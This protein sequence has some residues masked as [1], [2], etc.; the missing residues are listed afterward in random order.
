M[1]KLHLLHPDGSETAL[2][3]Q[4]GA[5]LLTVLHEHLGGHPSAPCGGNS[6]CLKC[7]VRITDGA[8]GFSPSLADRKAFS[9][10]QLESGW[11]LACRIIL[12]AESELWLEHPG[13]REGEVCETSLVGRAPRLDH[14]LRR[15]TLSLPPP[16]INDQRPDDQRLLG[17]LQQDESAATGCPLPVLRKLP[18]LLRGHSFRLDAVL[19]K[20]KI[21]DVRP[22]ASGRLLGAAVDLGT[23]TVALALYDLADGRLLHIASAGNRQAEFG[24]DVI[25]RITASGK[26]DGI[27]RLQRAAQE[28][29][30]TLLREACAACG[31][32]PSGLASL[33]VAG[34]TV[35]QHLLAGVSPSGIGASPFTPAFTAGLTLTLA[36]I[37][38]NPDSAEASH[39][40][41]ETAP[42]YLLPCIGPYVGGDITAGILSQYLT[43]RDGNHLLIDAG[44]NG[45]IVLRA[46][47]KLYACSTA[48]GPA[49]E[50]ARISCGM[51]ACDGAIHEIALNH[52]LPATK[53]ASADVWPQET[54][55][56]V[57]TLHGSDA[58]GVCGSGLLD[59]VARLLDTGL[60]DET[61][62]L[63]DADELTE[64]FPPKLRARLRDDG[65]L[66][67]DDVVLTRKD[68]REFQ[69]AC[70]AIQA[71]ARVLLKE[72]GI[73]AGELDGVLLAGGFGSH[74]SVGSALRTGLIPSGVSAEKVRAAGNAS[75]AGARLCL[76]EEAARQEAE[77]VRRETRCIELSGRA[78]FQE[79]YLDAME[80]P[81]P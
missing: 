39:R 3:A 50:G 46:D 70:A 65:V 34:N 31:S 68:I 20:N 67:A 44:T 22:P 63:A 79:F 49:F 58:S 18:E 45:E 17:T 6:T 29:I 37:L 56:C 26:P 81:S 38:P 40:W 11:R 25:S 78:D 35:M 2:H 47:G 48:A 12:R 9:P 53:A 32:C 51:R 23:T 24:D 75:L 72:A 66:L 42:A 4:T 28:T 76:L 36:D 8:A 59:A 43:E 14:A 64:G 21:L 41:P 60:I 16:E 62:A 54:D 74:L 55:I 57:Q 13:A 27:T 30:R 77:A 73:D 5:N 1:P 52:L 10:E 15:L 69:L 61:G 19:H 80:F 33:T 71:G 7:G